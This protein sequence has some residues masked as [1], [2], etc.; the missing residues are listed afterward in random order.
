MVLQVLNK[1]AGL[2][3]CKNFYQTEWIKGQQK[4]FVLQT[5]KTLIVSD[6]KTQNLNFIPRNF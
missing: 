3:S 4:S 1:A 5:Y 6:F 2:E